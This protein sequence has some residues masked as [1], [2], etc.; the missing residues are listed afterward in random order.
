MK[1]PVY[2]PVA[3]RGVSWQTAKVDGIALEDLPVLL[4]LDYVENGV[5]TV[6]A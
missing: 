6:T 1:T 4:F 5:R 3:C 2:V